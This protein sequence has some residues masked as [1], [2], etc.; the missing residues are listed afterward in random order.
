MKIN[1]AWKSKQE[2][3]EERLA[4]AWKTWEKRRKQ[5]YQEISDPI[6]L[7]YQRGEKTREQWLEAVNKVKELVPK[8]T[9]KE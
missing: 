1:L 7:Q 8:P 9:K 4:Q 2:A 5:A 3:E 6:Y